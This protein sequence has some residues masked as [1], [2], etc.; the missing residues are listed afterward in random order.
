M[1]LEGLYRNTLA[2]QHSGQVEVKGYIGWSPDNW[3][4]ACQTRM[5]VGGD[6]VASGN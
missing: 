6:A 4:R 2:I 5:A 1:E 3:D